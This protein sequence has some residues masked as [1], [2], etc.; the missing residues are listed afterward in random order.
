MKLEVFDFK[1][2]TT[3]YVIATVAN[4]FRETGYIIATVPRIFENRLNNSN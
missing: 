1:I 4:I 3:G 2:K